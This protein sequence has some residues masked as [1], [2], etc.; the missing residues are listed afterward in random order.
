MP[1]HSQAAS[2]RAASGVSPDGDQ[3]AG[4]RAGRVGRGPG[5]ERQRDEDDGPHEL[6]PGE[7]QE[8]HPVEGVLTEVLE[9][10]R[11][12]DRGCSRQKARPWHQ[13]AGAW[14][15]RGWCGLLS[16]PQGHG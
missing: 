13:A 4:N 3:P 8:E 11:E 10:D 1:S 12:V 14:P 9:H 15:S 5:E 2:R 16:R 6:G 7:N